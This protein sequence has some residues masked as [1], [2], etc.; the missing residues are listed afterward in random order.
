ML[1][2]SKATPIFKVTIIYNH[3]QK[4]WDNFMKQNLLGPYF[5][6]LLLVTSLCF[7]EVS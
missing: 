6:L 1:N 4:F 7:I 2:G 5:V 3:S